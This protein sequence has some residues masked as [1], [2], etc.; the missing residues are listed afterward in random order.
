MNHHHPTPRRKGG[1]GVKGLVGGREKGQIIK[2]RSGI[3]TGIEMRRYCFRKAEK[4]DAA[5]AQAVAEVSE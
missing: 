5:A 4:S 2:R 1:G 3:A